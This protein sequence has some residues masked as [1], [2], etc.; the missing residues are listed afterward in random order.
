MG[1]SRGEGKTGFTLTE[2]LVLMGIAA[3]LMAL[4]FPAVKSINEGNYTTTCSTQ[5]QQIAQALKVYHLDYKAVPAAYLDPTDPQT[6]PAGPGLDALWRAEYL[7]DRK[8]LHCPRD[9]DHPDTAQLAYYQ[10]Y[11]GRDEAAKTDEQEPPGHYGPFIQHKYLSTRG[12]TFEDWQAYLEDP[13]NNPYGGDYY[14]QL[15]PA[16]YDPI[17]GMVMPAFNSSWHPDDS[18]VVT[19]CNWHAE[20][21]VRQGQGQYL[22]LF[23]DGSVKVKPAILFTENC[24]VNDDGQEKTLYP[25]AAW[26]IEPDTELPPDFDHLCPE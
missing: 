26:R 13:E 1:R 19:W 16:V 7:G 3:V 4:T 21:I 2:L 8:T 10:S 24:Y 22:V 11:T 17:L 9:F 14:R 18:T 20:S 23:W 5:L 6:T 25:L 15:C 12:L